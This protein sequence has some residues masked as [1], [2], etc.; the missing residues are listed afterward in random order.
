MSWFVGSVIEKD[1]H[2]R[3]SK[4]YHKTNMN[5]IGK[6]KYIPLCSING[7]DEKKS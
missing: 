2:K 1:V 3:L 5:R 6:D 7:F 4:L